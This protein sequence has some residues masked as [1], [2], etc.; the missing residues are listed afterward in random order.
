VTP[1]ARLPPGGESITVGNAAYVVEGAAAMSKRKAE[2]EAER[3]REEA[4]KRNRGDEIIDVDM[5]DGE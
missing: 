3:Q 4:R 2:A 5:E 1:R